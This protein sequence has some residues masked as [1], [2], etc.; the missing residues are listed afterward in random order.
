VCSLLVTHARAGARMDT[1]LLGRCYP[2]VLRARP[3]PKAGPLLWDGLSLRDALRAVRKEL[4]QARLERHGGNVRAARQSLALTKTTF[5]RYLR[6]LGIKI[7]S[8]PR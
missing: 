5:H 4:I 2:E 8:T 1:D 3:N 7:T 6:S